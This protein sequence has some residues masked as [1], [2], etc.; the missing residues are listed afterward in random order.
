MRDHI[1]ARMADGH[2][3]IAELARYIATKSI[4]P[5]RLADCCAMHADGWDRREHRTG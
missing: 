5:R 4:Q 3:A 1:A 2:D